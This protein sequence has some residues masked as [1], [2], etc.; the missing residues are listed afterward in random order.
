MSKTVVVYPSDSR[1]LTLSV[2]FFTSSAFFFSTSFD[3]SA[4]SLSFFS[5]SMIFA[6]A[7]LSLSKSWS[8]F[9]T[10]GAVDHLSSCSYLLLLGARLVSQ[11]Q[12]SLAKS[13]ITLKRSSKKP[14]DKY[15]WYKRPST[16]RR[17][18]YNLFQTKKRERRKILLEKDRHQGALQYHQ[19]PLKRWPYKYSSQ[20]TSSM[21]QVL[22][23]A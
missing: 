20:Q 4:S 15:G 5:S 14:C 10:R 13:K 8:F 18:C 23:I 7:P 16:K 11:L 22:E 19:Y 17:N 3:L 6:L 2:H 1:Q 21:G 9:S 12:S